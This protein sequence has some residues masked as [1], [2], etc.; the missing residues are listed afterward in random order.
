MLTV[1]DVDDGQ[2]ELTPI[3]AG[4]GVYGTF[5]VAANGSWTYTLNNADTDTNALYVGQVVTD[6]IL[7]HSEDNSASQTI[8]VTITGTNDLPVVSGPVTA[9]FAEGSGTLSLQPACQCER[10]GRRR[11]A[12]GDSGRPASRGRELRRRVGGDDRLQWLCSWLGGWPVRLDRRLAGFAG[13]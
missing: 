9:S 6:T 4:A 10:S 1:T 11:R 2:A 12:G 8:T 13:Q 3:P 7:V 5:A